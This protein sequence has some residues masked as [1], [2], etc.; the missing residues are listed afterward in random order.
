MKAHK[1]F[2]CTGGHGAMFL[3]GRFEVGTM[4]YKVTDDGRMITIGPSFLGRL[5]FRLSSGRIRPH[6]RLS[7]DFGLG[8]ADGKCL[9][10]ECNCDVTT[11]GSLISG[12]E[13]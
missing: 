1:M 5:L 10:V 2:Q 6:A 7:R 3:T 8:C 13:K 12:P 11:T 4:L 9:T